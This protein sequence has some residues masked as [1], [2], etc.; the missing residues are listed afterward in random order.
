MACIACAPYRPASMGETVCMSESLPIWSARMLRCGICSS[1]CILYK[2]SSFGK[3]ACNWHYF[4]REMRFARGSL[5]VKSRTLI[6]KHHA[7]CCQASLQAFDYIMSVVT[8]T[9]HLNLI[10]LSDND[11]KA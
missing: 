7:K 6:P 9:N 1:L 3:V 5:R 11:F 10:H 4:I 8:V 2:I